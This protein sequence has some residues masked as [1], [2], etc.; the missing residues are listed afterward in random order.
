MLYP[1]QNRLAF[2]EEE[3]STFRVPYPDSFSLRE[4]RVLWQVLI[5]DEDLRCELEVKD[6][7]FLVGGFD[8]SVDDLTAEGAE[9]G[10]AEL[11]YREVSSDLMEKF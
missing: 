10:H 2:I 1:K 7:A 9:D 6:D 11:D 4:G 5:G 8:A 3:L